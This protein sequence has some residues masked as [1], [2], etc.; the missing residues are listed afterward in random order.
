[1]FVHSRQMKFIVMLIAGWLLISLPGLSQN[2][3]FEAHEIERLVDVL[4]EDPQ[5]SSD[6]L[7]RF[8]KMAELHKV[9][10][11]V[12]LNLT[13][14]LE[15]SERK[16]G[17][18]TEAYAMRLAKRFAQRW[19]TT[20]RRAAVRYNVD[21]EAIVAIL[22]VETSFGRFTGSHHLLS[23]FAST[24]LE[25]IEILETNRLAE[26]KPELRERIERKRDWA[27]GELRSILKIHRK[28]PRL[29]I[30]RIKGSYAGAFGKSQ[31]LPSSYLNFAV[32]ARSQGTPNLFWEPDAIHSVANYLNKHGYEQGLNKSV[33]RDAIHA[34]NRSDVYVN[35]VLGVA[36]KLVPVFDEQS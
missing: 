4:G 14:P 35:T 11:T 34:Y 15:L 16:Y 26:A 21:P 1:M 29:G 28:Y 2:Q 10:E 5:W 6:Q 36:H 18:F 24:Y 30:F 9:G 8:F 33:N 20:L 25:A 19:R 13:E 3:A 17:H 31:F 32:R 27:L 23:I 12:K 22:L 7:R